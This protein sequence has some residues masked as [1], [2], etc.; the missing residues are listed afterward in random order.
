MSDKNQEQQPIIVKKKKRHGGHHGGAWKVAYADF[1]TAM[2]AFFLVMWLVAQDQEVKEVVAAYFNDPVGFSKAYSGSILEGGGSAIMENINI[3]NESRMEF[4][5]MVQQQLKS[6]GEDILETLK[7][8]PEFNQV[9]SLIEIELTAE[10]L[11]IQ[12]IESSKESI[13]G[14]YKLGSRE[15]N[16]KG[17]TILTAISKELMKLKNN[18]VIE[19][20][21][22]SR[23]YV[24]NEKYSNWELS[25]DRANSARKLME[26]VGLPKGRVEAVR[27]YADNRLRFEDDPYDPRNRRIAIIVLNDYAETRFKE[28]QSS[29]WIAGHGQQVISDN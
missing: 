16:K 25:A 17:K 28:L 21:T 1:V 7:D 19:G 10:G 13:S 24:Y 12:L 15:L 20:H 9:Q 29:E 8:L 6:A 14:F 18:I 27:G 22:D 4:E 5:K 11:R 2:M 3:P 23:R 26:E